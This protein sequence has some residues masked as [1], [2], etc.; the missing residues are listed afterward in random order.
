MPRGFTVTVTLE[1]GRRLTHRSIPDC[2]CVCICVYVPS[3]GLGSGPLADF[4]S[5]TAG[6][7]A[8]T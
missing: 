6:Q 7:S 8:V 5:R 4:F 2:C 3:M 1:A